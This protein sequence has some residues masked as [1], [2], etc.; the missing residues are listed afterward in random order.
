MVDLYLL[1]FIRF[2]VF[3]CPI[4]VDACETRITNTPLDGLRC[5][6]NGNTVVWLTAHPQCVWRCLRMKTCRYINYKTDSEKCELG[7][8]ECESLQPAAGVMVNV[9]GPTRHDCLQWVSAHGVGLVPV[10]IRGGYMYVARL[11]GDDAVPVGWFRTTL[12]DFYAN[13]EGEFIGPV[14]DTDDNLEILT[15]NAACQ[16]PWM[17]YT[18]GEP[19]PFGAVPGG[20]L[21][22]G[23]AT[24]VAKVTHHSNGE[25]LVGYYNSK[26]GLAFYEY[27]GTQTS[28]SMDILVLLW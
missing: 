14:H 8:D 5:V 25:Q 21:P 10:Q 15:K 7:L 27:Y 9:Y 11:G 22:D 17:S 19:L 16:V 2:L 23:S 28:T 20:R 1:I 24:Y 4:L 26:S 3:L 13:M 6:T 18:D 12:R